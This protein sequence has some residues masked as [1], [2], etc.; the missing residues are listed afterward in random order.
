MAIKISELSP[1][2]AAQ[3]TDE[4]ETNQGGTSLRETNQQKVDLFNGVIQLEGTDQVA[5]LD[6]ALSGKADADG[7]NVSGTWGIDISGNADSAT[8]AANLSG[9]IT[10][11]QVTGLTTALAGKQPLD[12]T[13]TALA[14]LNTTAGVVYQSGTDAFTKITNGITGTVLAGTGGTPAFTDTLDQTSSG[15]FTFSSSSTNRTSVII[16]NSVTTNGD[17]DAVLSLIGGGPLGGSSYITAGPLLGSQWS[18]GVDNADDDAFKLSGSTGI[19]T[20]NK[21]KVTT[22]GYIS[23]LSQ[24]AFSARNTTLRSN[25]TGSGTAYT[26]LCNTA[27]INRGSD[28]STST[29]IFTAPVDGDYLFGATVQLNGVTSAMTDASLRILTSHQDYYVFILT[30]TCKSVNNIL[31]L[32]GTVLVPLTAGE[33]ARAIVTATGAGSDV[34]SVPN[35]GVTVF[36]GYLLP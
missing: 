17:G 21:L 15:S 16:R 22:D 24:P 8:T 25:V 34:A 35:N 14:G 20:A 31:T 33:T 23:F 30:G 4:F 7:S 28:Y 29:G 3:L 9:N 6:T 19:A 11:S 32:G 13:L 2:A 26:I 10:E 27:D 12:A 18:F 1:A 5:G 36:W